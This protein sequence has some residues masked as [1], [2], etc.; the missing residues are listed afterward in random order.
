MLPLRGRGILRGLFW[1]RLLH[2][3]WLHSL[4]AVAVTV[5][6]S[7]DLSAPDPVRS[8]SHL[9]CCSLCS[10]R[11]PAR[12]MY[13]ARSAPGPPSR[14]A[15]PP[16]RRSLHLHPPAE[17][18]GC[19]EVHVA[20]RWRDTQ[21]TG[22]VLNYC[23][24]FLQAT[25]TQPGTLFGGPR[26]AAA[27]AAAAATKAPIARRSARAPVRARAPASA[28]ANPTAAAPQPSLPQSSVR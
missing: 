20:W 28:A 14:G 6:E 24:H 17:K 16:P 23:R 25:S 11:R 15:P 8:V 4:A 10:G 9:P 27:A 12:H 18:G 19:C 22:G 7:R 3:F 21:T 5:H 13:T 1:L 2:S 26:P